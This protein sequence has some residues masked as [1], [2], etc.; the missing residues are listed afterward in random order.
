[1]FKDMG[2]SHKYVLQ[3]KI[4]SCSVLMGATSET[5]Q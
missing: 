1:M 2:K 5:F 4:F 3:K